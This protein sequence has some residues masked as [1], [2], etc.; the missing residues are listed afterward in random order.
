[1]FKLTAIMALASTVAAVPKWVPCDPQLTCDHVLSKA[2]KK[3]VEGS[4]CWNIVQ[5]KAFDKLDKSLQSE[6]IKAGFPTDDKNYLTGCFSKETMEKEF[7]KL[8]YNYVKY[9]FVDMMNMEYD[10][11]TNLK[12]SAENKGWFWLM[13]KKMTKEQISEDFK[14]MFDKSVFFG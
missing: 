13:D 5:G 10:I 8:N 9:S 11:V 14:G 7:G 3:K 12:F 6:Y 4:K 2:H 1:M